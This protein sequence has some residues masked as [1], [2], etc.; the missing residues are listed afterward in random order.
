MSGDLPS[1]G[2]WQDL[3]SSAIFATVGVMVV[4]IVTGGLWLSSHSQKQYSAIEQSR[5]SAVDNLVQPYCSKLSAS[6]AGATDPTFKC[7]AVLTY[8]YEKNV[9]VL[10]AYHPKSGRLEGMTSDGTFTS[11]FLA[12]P[13]MINEIHNFGDPEADKLLRA[14]RGP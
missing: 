2:Y 7:S 4:G 13:T 8:G 10:V 9:F 6:D 12:E 1:R 5:I 3:R 11:N 14:Y